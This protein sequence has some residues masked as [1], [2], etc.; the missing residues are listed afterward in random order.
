VSVA[1]SLSA[2]CAALLLACASNAGSGGPAPSEL[3]NLFAGY[4]CVEVEN[5]FDSAT[6]YTQY[7]KA[8]CQARLKAELEDSEFKYLL[9]AINAGRVR[10][11]ASAAQGCL[12]KI[13]GLGCSFETTR[14]L[15]QPPC[16]RAFQGSVKLGGNCAVNA[17]CVGASFC[18]LGDSCPGICTRQ[19]KAGASCEKNDQ[20][21]QGLT[22]ARNGTCTEPSKRGKSCGGGVAAQ[23]AADLECIDA[24]S[25]QHK[26]GTCKGPGD[27]LVGQLGEACDP[28]SNRLCVD[29]LSCAAQNTSNAIPSF[30]CAKPAEADAPCQFGLPTPCPDD[31]YCDADLSM[32]QFSGTCRDLPAAGE[33]CTNTLGARA[34]TPG[35]E[36]DSDQQCHPANRL[37]Q[38]CV[39]NRGC[40]GGSCVSGKCQRPKGCKL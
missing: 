32:G 6:I 1:R 27:L 37:G 10:Y 21:E 24:D 3:P 2:L 26:A 40:A 4:L 23:C 22:C 25:A 33:A 9:D 5:C 28:T 30:A 34:C 14:V 15:K 8:G 36:C 35:L 31:Q 17:D 20:C 29:G 38:P 7:G 16:D 39:S 19:Q 11:D 12:D 13:Q 18:K